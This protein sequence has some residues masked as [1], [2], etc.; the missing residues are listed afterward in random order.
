MTEIIIKI[1]RRLMAHQRSRFGK[2]P[3]N[4]RQ[5]PFHFLSFDFAKRRDLSEKGF[6]PYNRRA[7]RAKYSAE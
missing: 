2:R 7:L 3:K 6:N 1:S 4:K 5:I